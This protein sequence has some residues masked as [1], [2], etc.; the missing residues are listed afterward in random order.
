MVSSSGWRVGHTE[1]I[2]TKNPVIRG[3]QGTLRHQGC[4][5][6]IVCL[7]EKARDFPEWEK[8]GAGDI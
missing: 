8:V 4:M 6:K 3:R 5:I 1:R 2:M 7:R